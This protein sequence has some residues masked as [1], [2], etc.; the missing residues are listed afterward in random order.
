MVLEIIVVNGFVNRNWDVWTSIQI[1]LLAIRLL[2]IL[3]KLLQLTRLK[4]KVDKIVDCCKYPSSNQ[5]DF[6]LWASHYLLS[7]PGFPDKML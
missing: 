1:R 5:K 2:I 6:T 3:R 7:D 4:T